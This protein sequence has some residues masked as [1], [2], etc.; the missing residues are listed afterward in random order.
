MQHLKWVMDTVLLIANDLWYFA[1]FLQEAKVLSNNGG[2]NS[3]GQ[4]ADC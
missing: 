4:G 1:E 3:I 2:S